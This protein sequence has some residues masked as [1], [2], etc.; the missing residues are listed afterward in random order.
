MIIS[1]SFARSESNA[2]AD[3][4]GRNRISANQVGDIFADTFQ[5]MLF[6]LGRKRRIVE[7]FRLAA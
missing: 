3:Q 1:S 2:N 6:E 7:S 5:A 4:Q